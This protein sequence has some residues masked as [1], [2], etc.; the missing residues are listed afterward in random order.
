MPTNREVSVWDNEI[1]AVTRVIG[2]RFLRR[3]LRAHAESYLAWIDWQPAEELG[4]HT[5]QIKPRA[6]VIEE[7]FDLRFKKTR[8]D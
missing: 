4:E 6:W 7:C 3:D 1:G 5:G 2:S 8:A